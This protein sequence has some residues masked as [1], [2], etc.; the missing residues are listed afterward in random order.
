MRLDAKRSSYG[1][2]TRI[3]FS[4]ENRFSSKL[5]INEDYKQNMDEEVKIRKRP[6][7]IP[8][9]DL[10]EVQRRRGILNNAST[11]YSTSVN[12]LIQGTD[13]PQSNSNIPNSSQEL[14]VY[15]ENLKKKKLAQ[16]NGGKSKESLF[17]KYNSLDKGNGC[18]AD[19]EEGGKKMIK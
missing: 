3:P 17:S 7:I 2:S 16:E 13:N 10:I 11:S 6:S 15:A 8:P 4:E 14:L 1:V 9:L 12:T 5:T 18:D 19:N